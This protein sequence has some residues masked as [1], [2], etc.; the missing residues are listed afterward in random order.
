MYMKTIRPEDC[1]LCMEK[2]IQEKNIEAM[3]ALYEPDATFILDSG[4]S[5]VGLDEIRKA[6]IPFLNVDNFKFTYL[7]AFP[8]ADNKIAILRGHWVGTM[9]DEN[10]AT[11]E[12]SGNDIE[13]VR[14]QDDGTWKFIID[15]PT[16]ADAVTSNR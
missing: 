2:A 6:L 10:G 8:D 3:L 5:A 9:K 12:I 16:G 14:L 11:L 1:D 13:V 4:E 7:K 15:H